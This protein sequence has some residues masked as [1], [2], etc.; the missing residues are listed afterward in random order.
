MTNTKRWTVTLSPDEPLSAVRR[1]LEGVGFSIDQVLEAI[2]VVTG[3]ADEQTAKKARGVK[4]VQDVSP[5]GEVDI[6]PPD[7]PVT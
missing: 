7:A 2:G 5:E 4:G 3:Q 1:D 6:G